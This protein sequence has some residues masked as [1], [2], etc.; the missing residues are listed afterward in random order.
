MFEREFA[1]DPC[2]ALDAG[3]KLVPLVL[4]VVEVLAEAA[5]MFGA[6][7]RMKSGAVEGKPGGIVIGNMYG[8]A[9]LY[10]NECVVRRGW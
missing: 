6:K 4:F 3:T 2:D 9:G 5:A 1:V 10:R 7:S 8:S